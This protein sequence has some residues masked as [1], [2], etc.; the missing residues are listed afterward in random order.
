VHRYLVTGTDTDVG[1]TRVAAALALALRRA[2]RAPSIVKLAQTGLPAGTPGDAAHAGGLAGVPFWELARFLKAADPFTA[3]LAEGAPPLT[4]RGLAAALAE[5]DGALVAETAGGLMVPLN[6]REHFG[7][8][9]AQARLTI[10]L[11]VGLRL[12]CMNHA[13]LTHALCERLGLDVAGAVLVER[14]EPTEPGYA[15]EV[16][17]VLQGKLKILGILPFARD[18]PTAVAAGASLFDPLVYAE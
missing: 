11:V 17:R 2:G 15:G 6:E 9:A 16:E 8:V 1:K 10:L 3:A 13:L 5:I 14:W 4:A 12:G 18:E 7:D